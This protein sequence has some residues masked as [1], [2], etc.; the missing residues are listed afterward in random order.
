MRARRGRNCGA[1]TVRSNGFEL[2]ASNPALCRLELVNGICHGDGFVTAAAE[3]RI[4]NFGKLLQ[5][6]FDTRRIGMIGAAEHLEQELEVL[7]LSVRGDQ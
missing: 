1:N 3:D 4:E 5:E 6:K 2:G 7:H